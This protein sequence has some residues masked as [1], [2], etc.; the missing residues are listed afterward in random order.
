MLHLQK[1]IDSFLV[2]LVEHQFTR[3]VSLD[4]RCQMMI[5]T[6]PQLISQNLK[7][8][9]QPK[10][11]L[12]S[13]KNEGKRAFGIRVFGVDRAHVHL[14]FPEAL[15]PASVLTSLECARLAD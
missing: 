12:A 8:V 6:L 13:F 10:L 3:E 2:L 9:A 7:I 14:P 15:A 5:E 4:L 11:P 1:A